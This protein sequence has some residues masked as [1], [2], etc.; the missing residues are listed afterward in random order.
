M[1]LAKNKISDNEKV[2]SGNNHKKQSGLSL[3][4]LLVAMVIGLF[5]LAGI[6]TSYLSSKKNQHC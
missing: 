6:T 4:E 5:L 1:I 2:N 3:I